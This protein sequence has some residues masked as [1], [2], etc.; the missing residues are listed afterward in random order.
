MSAKIWFARIFRRVARQ[1]A[2]LMSF[3]VRIFLIQTNNVESQCAAHMPAHVSGRRGVARAPNEIYRQIIVHIVMTLCIRRCAA[4]TQENLYIIPNKFFTRNWR[5]VVGQG[6]ICGWAPRMRNTTKRNENR[7]A[8]FGNVN[9][10]RKS[11][12]LPARHRRKCSPTQQCRAWRR[13]CNTHSHEEPAL[14]ECGGSSSSSQRIGANHFLL[15]FLF[16]FFLVGSRV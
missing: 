9:G 4:P 8:S 5:R 11:A 10:K 3:I 13:L 7:N 6:V 14:C 12:N 15:A 1:R 16:C 2:R